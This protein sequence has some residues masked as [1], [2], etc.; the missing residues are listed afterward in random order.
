MSPIIKS[1][2]KLPGADQFGVTAGLSVDPENDP[3]FRE[4]VWNAPAEVKTLR[5][6]Y[7]HWHP[8]VGQIID[9]VPWVR[10]YCNVAGRALD[11]WSFNDRVTLLGDAAHTHG[12]AFAAG[13]SLAIDDAFALALAF[14]EIYPPALAPAIGVAS[15]KLIGQVF[16]LYETTRKPHAAK[17]LAHVHEGRSKARARLDKHRHGTPESDADFRTRMA[18]RGDPVWVNEYDVEAAFRQVVI[19]KTGAQLE[20][21]AVPQIPGQARL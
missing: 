21:N 13:V 6:R 16:D 5:E 11:H 1:L 19:T 2:I 12:G 10:R 4:P 7:V 18:N 8:V 15:P 3:E 17:V 20:S 9:R 14:D